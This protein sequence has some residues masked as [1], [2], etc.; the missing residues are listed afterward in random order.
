MKVLNCPANTEISGINPEEPFSD[1]GRELD[2]LDDPVEHGVTDQGRRVCGG[3]LVEK[4]FTAGL[5][6]AH[7]GK[8]LLRD[9]GVGLS[10]SD[11]L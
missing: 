2:L 9:L 1:S 11:P 7:R 5:D 6:G 4:I 3:G 8:K 10:T